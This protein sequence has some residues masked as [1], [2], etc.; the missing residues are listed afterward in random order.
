[1]QKG[2]NGRHLSFLAAVLP[3]QDVVVDE[4]VDGAES[5][6]TL[7]QRRFGVQSETTVTVVDAHAGRTALRLDAQRVQVARVGRIAHQKRPHL[8]QAT[9]KRSAS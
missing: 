8:E 1:M 9:T 2:A 3:L 7:R 6:Q 4:I 5:R